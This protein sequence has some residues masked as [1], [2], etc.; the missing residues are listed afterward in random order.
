MDECLLHSRF[1]ASPSP[2]PGDLSPSSPSPPIPDGPP[3]QHPEGWPY[4]FTFTLPSG[5][6]AERVFVTLRPHL[7]ELLVDLSERVELIL[8]T[9][10][11]SVY[12]SPVLS[13]LTSAYGAKFRHQLYRPS[14][15]SFASFPRYPYQKDLRTLG[16]DLRRTVLVDNNCWG[17]LGAPDNAVV[18]GDF[19]GESREMEDD[20]LLQVL[21]LIRRLDEM[22]SA[23]GKDGEVG[24]VRTLLRQAIQ[25]RE[26]LATQVD[27]DAIE[28]EWEKAQ[29]GK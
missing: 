24:D 4:H 7:R 23:R 11:L 13:H 10:A 18:V 2:Y 14:T 20:T 6:T 19:L 22:T 3:F 16:R 1:S 8:F 15:A 17:M 26:K 12:A 27:F 28:K 9:S 21:T 5:V 25:F 29:Q